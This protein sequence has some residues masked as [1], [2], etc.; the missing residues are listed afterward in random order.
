MCRETKVVVVGGGV[1][2]TSAAIHLLRAGVG[3]VT[4][5]ERD[6]VAQGTSGAG[7]GFVAP[8]SLGSPDEC[9]AEEAALA[10]YAID[11][12]RELNAA[13]PEAP[14]RQRGCL[15]MAQTERD[16]P[17]VERRHTEGPADSRIVE[18]EEIEKLTGGVV[19]A[20]GILRGVYHPSSAQISA[21]RATRALAALFAAEGGTLRERTPVRGLVVE[22][23]RIAGVDT[24]HGRIEADRVVIAAGAWTNAVLAELGQSLP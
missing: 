24:A 9:G 17:S 23:G 5:V 18:P 6:G 3:H 12:Y 4:L 20:A 14:Y 8:W 13:R 19:R 2:G 16:W 1:L 22:D 10:D 15:W 11:F 7:A 21:E